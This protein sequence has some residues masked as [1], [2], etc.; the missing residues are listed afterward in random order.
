MSKEKKEYK[1][2]CKRVYKLNKEAGAWM[3]FEAP[4]VC[5]DF[6]YTKY[7]EDSFDWDDSPWDHKFWGTLNGELAVGRDKVVTPEPEAMT[8]GDLMKM[9]M[10][11]NESDGLDMTNVKLVIY[12][13]DNDRN[14][15]VGVRYDKDLDQVEIDMVEVR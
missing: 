4:N 10:Q 12:N 1:K 3:M 11:P 6:V 14:E 7:L 9:L 13:S 5:N 8:A 2:L 15:I